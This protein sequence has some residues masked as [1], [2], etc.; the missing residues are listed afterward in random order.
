MPNVPKEAVP[1]LSSRTADSD[2]PRLVGRGEDPLGVIAEHVA[3][4]GGDEAA[5]D[6][7]EEGDAE[8]R[9][10]AAD[11]LG[12]RRLGEVHLLRGGAERARC[13]GGEEVLELLQSHREN[14]ELVKLI[15]ASSVSST[16]RY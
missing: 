1:P 3:G 16:G 13:E 14:L 2:S 11:L 9:L 8:L 6:P 12:E 5:A 15:K 7:L 10:Q 4:L